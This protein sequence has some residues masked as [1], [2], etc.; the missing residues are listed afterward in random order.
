MQVSPGAELAPGVCDM[1]WKLFETRREGIDDVPSQIADEWEHER[2]EFAFGE[3]LQDYC[4]LHGLVAY[5]RTNGPGKQGSIRLG[6]HLIASD[7]IFCGQLNGEAMPF[8]TEAQAY[9][10]I[11]WFVS[12]QEQWHAI[13][14]KQP[15]SEASGDAEAKEADGGAGSP[16]GSSRPRLH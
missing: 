9:E 7:F 11:Q 10:I 6:R 5:V 16:D 4:G 13:Y 3:D 15:D 1:T 8:H 12:K 2:V 14:S